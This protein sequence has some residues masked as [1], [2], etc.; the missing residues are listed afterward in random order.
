[1]AVDIHGHPDRAVPE[2]IPYVGQA[3][4]VLDQQAGIGMPESVRLQVTE[5]RAAQEQPPDSLVE[6]QGRHGLVP[7]VQSREEPLRVPS[8]HDGLRVPQGQ[9]GLE[10]P[11]KLLAHVHAPGLAGLGCA[12]LPPSPRPA[13]PE[14]LLG[15]VQVLTFEGQGFTDPHAGAREQQDER[16]VLGH[17]LLDRREQCRQ[18]TGRER[19]NGVDFGGSRLAGEATQ[20]SSWI[21][22]DEPRFYRRVETGRQWNKDR[23]ERAG[24]E[25]FLGKLLGHHRLDPLAGESGQG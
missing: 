25:V 23:A 8:S 22:G 24:L 3:L 4:P 16:I 1:V 6:L 11:L 12:D 7:A 18:L 13:H 14:E 17:L 10:D 2:L 19:V 20:P 15:K 21:A 5:P 9:V